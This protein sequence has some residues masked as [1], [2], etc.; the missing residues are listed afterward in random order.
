MAD[1]KGTGLFMV[2]ADIPAELEDEYNRWYNEEHLDA[3]L[4][5]PGILNAARYVALRGGP[6]HLACYELESPGVIDSQAYLTHQQNRTEWTK[7]MSPR[8]IG[9]NF[10]S[11]VYRQIFPSQMPQDVARS[12]MAPALQIG[13]MGVAAENDEEFNQWYNTIYIP[14]YEKVPGCIRGRR[15]TAVKGGPQYAT[16][17]E[18]QHE[19]VSQTPEWEVAR[20]SHPQSAKVRP[21]MTHAS[22]SPGVYKKIFP[23]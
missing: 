18:F 19:N 7:R 4:A 23:L 9:T 16:V 5:I 17:Y 3:L 1:K 10:V 15:Y 11:N 13:R 21:M 14:N 20:D 12:D 6:K 22:G 8:V 2:W